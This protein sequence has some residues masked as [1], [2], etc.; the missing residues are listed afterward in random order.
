MTAV[1]GQAAVI[2]VSYLIRNYRSG[3]GT[4]R[5]GVA[6]VNFLIGWNGRLLVDLLKSFAMSD[7]TLLA[8][9]ADVV[10]LTPEVEAKTAMYRASIRPDSGLPSLVWS[11]NSAFGS[12]CL[13][14]HI[15]FA[16][17]FELSSNHREAGEE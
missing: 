15:R 11:L 12:K 8:Q 10:T 1:T 6:S 17:T 14:L 4:E 5:I 9:T 13:L 16:S 7:P 2:G 3:N